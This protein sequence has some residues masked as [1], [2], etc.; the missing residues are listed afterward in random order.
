MNKTFFTYKNK[1]PKILKSNTIGFKPLEYTLIHKK[2]L[3]EK[4]TS[5]EKKR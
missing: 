2:T 5:R 4:Y 3:S 1:K